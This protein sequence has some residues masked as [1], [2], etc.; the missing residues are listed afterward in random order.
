[1]KSWLSLTAQITMKIG[2]NPVMASPKQGIT[3]YEFQMKY[4][5]YLSHL[6]A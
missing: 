5:E 4:T 2:N 1:M 6:T 3:L